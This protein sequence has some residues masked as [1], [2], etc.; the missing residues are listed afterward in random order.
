MCE[1]FFGTYAY[2]TELG[3]AKVGKESQNDR[4]DHLI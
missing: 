3:C 2:R 1:S 4:K